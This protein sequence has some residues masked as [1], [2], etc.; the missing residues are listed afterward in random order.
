MP[1]SLTFTLLPVSFFLFSSSDGV[2]ESRGKLSSLADLSQMMVF[3][4]ELWSWQGRL[5]KTLSRTHT[6][7]HTHTHTIH[8][9]HTHHHS[10]TLWGELLPAIHSH[11]LH[12][13]PHQHHHQAIRNVDGT[14]Q[15]Q[16]VCQ[17]LL[18]WVERT[19]STSGGRGGWFG[20]KKVFKAWK[21][22]LFFGGEGGQEGVTSL[23]E[24]KG[25]KL[26]LCWSHDD[27]DVIFLVH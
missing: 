23:R 24:R 2:S 22:D 15:V 11:P 7:T 5:P 4:A 13:T 10:I 3:A 8:I 16:P 20:M 17:H 26:S 27:S 14:E 25:N 18:W 21:L 1:R 9:P 6:H 19:S 12:T